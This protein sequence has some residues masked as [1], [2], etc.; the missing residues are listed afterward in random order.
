MHKFIH[1]GP[2]WTIVG[3]F[4]LLAH[5]AEPKQ[6]VSNVSDDR[7]EFL[8]AELAETAERQQLAL[9]EIVRYGDSATPYLF[10]FLGDDKPLATTN[11]K[12]L[13]DF[14]NSFE[15]YFLETASTVDELMVL[16]LCSQI[17]VCDRARNIKDIK[18]RKIQREKLIAVCKSEFAN[19]VKK[20]SK[21]D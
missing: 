18:N 6:S 1:F 10:R 8:V 9:D 4:T 11:V 13:N 21:H 19:L 20:C 12:L 14:D 5:G 16:Y 17:D 3:L 15:K 2:Q 7:I